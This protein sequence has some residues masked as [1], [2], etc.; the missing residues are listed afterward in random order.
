MSKD[1]PS[2]ARWT[3]SVMVDSVI[4]HNPNL[5]AYYQREKERTCSGNYA[6]VL[7][8]KKLARMLHHMMITEQSWKWENP[9]LTERKLLNLDRIEE[10]RGGVPST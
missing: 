1:G 8:M 10:E 9:E 2:I 7:T 6:H 5:R 4:L 3:L